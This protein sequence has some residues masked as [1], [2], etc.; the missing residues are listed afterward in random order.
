MR[1]WRGA[2]GSLGE[3]WTHRH[4]IVSPVEAI[5]ELGKMSWDVLIVDGTIGPSDCCLVF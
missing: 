3:A 5:F 1:H 2:D 4:K